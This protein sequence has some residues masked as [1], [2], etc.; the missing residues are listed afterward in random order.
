[1]SPD[2]EFVAS[3]HQRGHKKPYGRQ[4]ESFYTLPSWFYI[5][6]KKH[7]IELYLLQRQRWP[8]ALRNFPIAP[9]VPQYIVKTFNSMNG[10]VFVMVKFEQPVKLPDGRIGNA[11]R[12]GGQDS[13]KPRLKKL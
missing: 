13:D 2:P 9:G 6:L 12:V 8:D 4:N 7:L 3:S 10:R 1:M 5:R 11:F